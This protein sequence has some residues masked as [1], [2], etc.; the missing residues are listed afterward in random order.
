ME[1]GR[2]LGGSG[3][4]C[5]PAAWRALQR[6]SNICL[7]K[8]GVNPVTGAVGAEDGVA[9]PQDRAPRAVLGGQQSG[10]SAEGM[11]TV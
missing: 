9:Q 8:Q 10:P 6:L 11:M 7:G 1:V 5:S 4:G 2:D 3:E